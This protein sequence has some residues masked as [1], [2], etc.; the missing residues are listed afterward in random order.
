LI[1][2][3]IHSTQ[4]DGTKHLQ[5]FDKESKMKYPDWSIA[6]LAR[7]DLQLFRDGFQF[8]KGDL[9]F[10]LNCR[11]LGTHLKKRIQKIID[12]QKIKGE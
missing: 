9:D 11:G 12:I 10:Y 4:P 6:Q 8:D 1:A 7:H 3:K 2:L 5:P